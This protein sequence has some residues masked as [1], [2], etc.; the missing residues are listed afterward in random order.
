M[1]ITQPCLSSVT[2]YTIAAAAA[3]PVCLQIPMLVPGLDYTFETFIQ[4]LS[5]RGISDVVKV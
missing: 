5:D 1:Y 2:V 4:C 3:M